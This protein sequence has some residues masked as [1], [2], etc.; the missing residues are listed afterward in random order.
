MV[1]KIKPLNMY[2]H[3]IIKKLKCALFIDKDIGNDIGAITLFFFVQASMAINQNGPIIADLLA[4]PIHHHS[5]STIALLYLF[6]LTVAFSFMWALFQSMS[7]LRTKSLIPPQNEEKRNLSLGGHVGFDSLP[8][9]L[10]SKSVTQGFCFN[11]LCVG[12]QLLTARLN[13]TAAQLLILK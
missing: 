10:V 4:W 5:L 2:M 6:K 8:D 9:Q 3:D 7:T 11:I 13:S 1:A 12:K